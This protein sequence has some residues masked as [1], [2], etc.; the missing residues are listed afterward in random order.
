M[1]KKIVVFTAQVQLEPQI[2]GILIGEG[3]LY[4]SANQAKLKSFYSI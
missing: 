2:S 1:K 4:R 3:S